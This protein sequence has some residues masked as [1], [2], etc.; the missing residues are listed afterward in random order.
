MDGDAAAHGDEALD[1]IPGD[2]LAAAGDVGHQV[3]DPF[4]D[5]VI[6]GLVAERRVGLLLQFLQQAAIFLLRRRLV[7]AGVQVVD[8]LVDADVAAADAG[9]QI[10]GALQIEAAQHVALVDLGHAE[11]VAIQLL[12]EQL[13]PGDDVLVPIQLSEPGGHLGPRPAGAQEA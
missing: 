13:A 4:H 2:R 3:A 1:G 5:Y 7:V 9:Q 6:L 12:V 8:H 10:V 11:V